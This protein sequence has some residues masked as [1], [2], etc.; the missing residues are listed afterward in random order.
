MIRYIVY[1]C[2]LVSLSG[3]GSIPSFPSLNPF[4]LFGS[5][6]RHDNTNYA[7]ATKGGNS[8]VVIEGGKISVNY[9]QPENSQEGASLKIT[10]FDADNVA[11]GKIAAD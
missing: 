3:C 6:D 11:R 1:F 10:I 7:P 8:M 9:Q 5:K 2:L 4:N